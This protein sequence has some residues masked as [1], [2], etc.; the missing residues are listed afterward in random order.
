M[1][2]TVRQAVTMLGMLLFSAISIFPRANAAQAADLPIYG[3]ALAAGWADWSWKTTV[4]TTNTSPVHGGTR[5]ISVKIN[6]GW[7]ALY[8]HAPS[9]DL[10]N[11]EK[12]R[13]WIYN[14]ASGNQRLQLVANGDVS[15]PISTQ[16]NTWTE[17]V[18]ALS[19]LGSPATLSALYWQDTTNSAQPVF[20][21]DDITLIE[22]SGP[23]PPPPPPTAG[24]TLSID[25][26]AARHPISEG[27]YG[28]NFADEQLA[29]ELRLPVRRRGGN[30]TSRY[31]W[32]NDTYNTG[33]DWYFEN[34]PEENDKVTELPHGSAADRFV[35]Q[36]RRTATKSLLTVPLIGWVAKRRLE[37]HPYDCGFKVSNYGA[38]QSVDS[39]DSDCGN[40]I[41]LGGHNLT[42]NNPT[43]TSTAITPSFVTGW[44]NHLTEKYGTAANG[45]VAYYNLDNEPMLWNSTHRDV[46]PSPTTYDELRDST[47]QYAAAVKTA[48][49]SAKTL[50]PV[51]W[52]WCAY[53]F[54]AKDGC[55]IGEDYRAHGN[56][57]FTPWYL[58]QL[59]SYEVQHGLRLLD[60][61]DLHYY[62]QASGVALSSAGNASTQALRL[63]STRSLWDPT[64]GDESW[65]SEAVR[66]IP[67]MKEWVNSEYPGTKLAITEYNWGALDHINGALAQ[68]DVLGIFGREGLDLATIWSP[69]TTAQPGA[70][71]FRLFRNY[72]GNGGAFGDVSVQA[73]SSDQ[74]TLS[75]YAAQRS[76]DNALT[77]LVINKTGSAKTSSISLTGFTPASSAQ[78][79]RYSS[80]PANAIEHLADQAITATGFGSSFPGNSI[81]L[82]AIK[83][84]ETASE[85]LTIGKMGGGSG[86]IAPDRGT[87]TWNDTTGSGV[88]SHGAVVNL[89]ATADPG[90]IFSG[91]SGACSGSVNSCQV[92]MTSDMAVGAAFAL[93]T[94]FSAT[95]RS[96]SLP[97]QVTFSNASLPGPMQWLWDFGDGSA[98]TLQNPTH[99][100]T[101]PGSYSVSL[102]ASGAAGTELSTKSN[103]IV[104]SACANLPVR[105]KETA[106]PYATIQSACSAT[107]SA[108]TLQL[109]ALEFMESPTLSKNFPVTLLG[110]YGCDYSTIPLFSTL[111]GSLTISGETV[112]I[113]NIVIR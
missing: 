52:G 88:Y 105:I 32:Q 33:S 26:S 107:A 111:R 93:K 22:R 2:G 112:T 45:G 31:N 98:S 84:V 58:R 14:S 68:A 108:A 86:T 89:T 63:R 7:A 64:Y 49:P 25:V 16:A 100:Y 51:L 37:G 54:S 38:Q 66:L 87:I 99:V 110:G 21:L 17:V 109:Q 24:P 39:W 80:S 11:Y 42:G 91:W 72:D 97:L 53:L 79:Y 106:A 8:L 28:M 30:S 36:D 46:H 57:P 74:T 56:T 60:Y 77:L 94:D 1:M 95:P 70:F 48:D 81:T 3:D 9:I 82:F 102:T 103:Y 69:P 15:A 6:E 10:S 92:T 20:Y 61:L 65:I 5:S 73:A 75:L 113:A 62:P 35:E 96:G 44:V 12:L 13:F 23:P 43:D 19:D 67:R 76:A 90:S 29:T 34:I 18:I 40:G 41:D 83:P 27:I 78:V 85:T 71:A 47:F 101:M 55:G 4:N 104:V 59:K 50:G